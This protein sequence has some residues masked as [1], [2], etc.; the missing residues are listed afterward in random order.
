M[1]HNA[2]P[3]EQVADL[4]ASVFTAFER[5]N[6]RKITPAA[7][8]KETSKP[9]SEARIR[10]SITHDALI[11]FEDGCG[12]RTLKRHL[13]ALGLTPDEYRAKWGLPSNYPMVSPAY[14]KFRSNIARATGL[15]RLGLVTG[16]GFSTSPIRS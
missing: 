2:A 4:I 1:R 7:L 10:A 3:P 13:T 5:L 11:S 9:T 8:T 15:G 16:H 6:M 12:Y 14:S